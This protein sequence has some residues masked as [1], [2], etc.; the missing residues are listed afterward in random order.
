[1]S[2]LADG[3]IG[4]ICWKIV[5]HA[6]IDGYSR[7]VTTMRASNNNCADTVLD[8]FVD[9]VHSYGLPSCVQGDHGVENLQVAAFMENFRGLGCGS[10]IFGWQAPSTAA[11]YFLFH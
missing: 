7:L 3:V 2:H 6:F 5:V 4:L 9:G 1:M 11:T 8:V 10:Y